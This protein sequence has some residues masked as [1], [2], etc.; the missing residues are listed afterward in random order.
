MHG[1]RPL[2]R[3]PGAG[4]PA[5]VAVLCAGVALL[6]GACG[7]GAVRAVPFDAADSPACLAVADHWPT[8]VG[9]HEP[10]VTAVQSRGVAAWGD[11]PIVARCG[12]QP[13]G[14]T[15]EQC[16]DVNGVDWVLTELDDGAMFTT[17][18]RDP[19]IEVLV[20]D[21]HESAP[22]LLPVF[23]AAA[24]QVPQTMGRC[25]AVGD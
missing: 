24:E 23:G 9:P 25:T 5:L 2:R 6:A 21:T 18:G 11:P 3:T 1:R 12:K 8:T 16:L 20:P 13:P 22:L 10:R 19:A 14:P 17:Y 15:T 4:R 7:D